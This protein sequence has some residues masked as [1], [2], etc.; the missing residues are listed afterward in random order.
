M[1]SSSLGYDCSRTLT[2]PETWKAHWHTDDRERV[3]RAVQAYRLLFPS[4]SGLAIFKGNEAVGLVPN[5]VFGLLET[6]PRHVGL[7][8]NSDTPYGPVLLDLREGPMVVELPCPGSTTVLSSSTK[9]LSMI[10]VSRSRPLPPNKSVRPTERSNSVSPVK[11]TS[12][13]SVLA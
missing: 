12:F 10:E 2:D 9:S 7:T 13:P 3:E 4:V 5:E 6:R 11:T 1:F 8:L